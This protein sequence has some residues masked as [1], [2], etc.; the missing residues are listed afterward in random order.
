MTGMVTLALVGAGPA[1]GQSDYPSRPV[2]M[3]V[4]SAVGGGNDLIARLLAQGLTERMGRQVVVENRTGAGTAIGTE[5]VARSRPDGYTLLMSPAAF[6]TLPAVGARVPYEVMNDFSPVTQAAT[7]PGVITLHPSVPATTVRGLIALARS[8][9]GQ[10]LFSSAGVGTHPHLSIELLASMA[11]VRFVHVPYRGTTPGLAD[12][13]AGQVSL[14][15][16]NIL[17]VLPHVRSGRL[18]ALGVTTLKSS[19]AAPEIPPIAESGLPGY[20]SVQWYGLLAPAGTSREI[21]ARLYTETVAI[22]GAADN[23]RRLAADGAEVVV[24]TPEMFGGFLKAEFAKWARV[25]QE[26]NIKVE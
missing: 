24:S 12:L 2:R 20:E 23:R 4:P 17:Q 15:T 16:A 1:T 7:L 26:A 8:R 10:L 9:P 25:A 21:V 5:V 11:G 6:V 22:L 18:R 19:A 13:I 14:A 3:V